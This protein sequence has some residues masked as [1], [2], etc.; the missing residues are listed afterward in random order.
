MVHGEKQKC[1]LLFFI[2]LFTALCKSSFETFFFDYN[3]E[4]ILITYRT[5]ARN[6]KQN[7]KKKKKKMINVQATL[8]LGEP[9]EILLISI[10]KFS[11]FVI[12]SEKE[13]TRK[14]V[15]NHLPDCVFHFLPDL[16]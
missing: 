16:F 9:F 5:G 4:R 10:I 8:S 12:G 13:L 2:F 3:N 14:T 15:A 7:K 11:V 6:K 1:N